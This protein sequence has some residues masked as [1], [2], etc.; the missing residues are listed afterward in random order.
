MIER[1]SL[2]EDF[3]RHFFQVNNMAESFFLPSQLFSK[4]DVQYNK[5]FNKNRTVAVCEII[6]SYSL[7]LSGLWSGRLNGPLTQRTWGREEYY[8]FSKIQLVGQTYWDKTTLASK[9]RFSRHCFGFQSQLFSL[10]VGY[11]SIDNRPLVGFY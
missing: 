11:N 1:F 8:C 7:S 10:L 9:T 5:V 6:N 4:V 3:V 2:M